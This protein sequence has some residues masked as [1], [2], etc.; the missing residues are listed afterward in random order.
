MV[1]YSYLFKQIPALYKHFL[2]MIYLILST[3]YLVVL[4][5]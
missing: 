5:L 4:S 1:K 2:I 3:K